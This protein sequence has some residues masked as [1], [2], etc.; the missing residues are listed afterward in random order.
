MKFLFITREGRR[1]PGARSRCYGLSDQLAQKGL[2]AGVFSFSDNLGAKSGKD[3]IDFTGLQKINYIY[4][5][6]KALC[7]ENNN[8]IFIVNRFNYHTLS[9]WLA[10]KTKGIPF[11]FDMDDWEAKEE[12]DS[13]LGLF[14]KSKAAIL[15]GL[16]AKKSKFCIAG[17]L[18]LK[19][20][21]SQ[22]KKEVYY[23]P[24]GVDVNKF[25]PSLHKEK[26]ELT[27]SWHGSINRIEIIGY[28]KFIIECFLAVYKKYPSIK[29]F[30]AGEGMFKKQLQQLIGSYA[31]ENLAYKGW[32]L[33]Q[34]MAGYLDSVDVGL[35]PLL[36]KT[37]FNLSKSPV[38]LLEYMAKGLPAVCSNIGE[39]AS[40]ITDGENSFLADSKEEFIEKMQVLIEDS[41]L[42]LRM[43]RRARE[44][45]VEK[46]S[47]EVLGRRLYTI[48][49]EL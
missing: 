16:F 21:L 1:E 40:I 47:L 29:L 43:G 32:I 15:T 38:K 22:F 2:A 18:Y 28:I 42:R 30:I 27:F 45:V 9:C 11:I 46:Y 4:K 13:Y 10:S 49:K 37:R 36:D 19:D 25:K 48:L 6:Y 26:K 39:A 31:C 17:S 3:E 35:V 44:A 7:R 5:G 12:I 34:D 41:A 33:P 24:T 23:L 14:P 8:T 20:Y